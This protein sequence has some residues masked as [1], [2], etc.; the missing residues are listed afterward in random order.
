MTDKQAIFDEIKEFIIGGEKDKAKELAGLHI[1]TIDPLELIENG[2][3]PAMVVV[4]D[5]FG[6]AEIFLPEMMKSA[7]AFEEVM[8]V[9]NPKILESGKAVKKIGTIVIGTVRTDVHEIGKNIVSKIF[10]TGGFEVYDL[11]YDV[12]VTDFVLKAQEV[13]ADIIAASALMTTTMPYQKDIIDLL[14]S[15][16]LR[17]KYQIMVGG[18]AVTQK[19]ADKICADGYAEYAPEAVKLAKE[20]MKK[21]KGD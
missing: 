14:E 2:L 5:K 13:N 10:A 11:G 17:D 6:N 19:W 7:K 18:G 16:G 20:L 15:M 9:L 1:E 8:T 3:A 12:P 21:K 4:G